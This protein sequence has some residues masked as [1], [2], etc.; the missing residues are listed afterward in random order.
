MYISKPKTLDDEQSTF[1]SGR[2]AWYSTSRADLR[3]GIKQANND[4]RRK[5]EIYLGENNSQSMWQ[6]IQN[7]T[8]YKRCTNSDPNGDVS[9]CEQL[10]CFFARFAANMPVFSS[11]PQPHSGS[12]VL[13]LQEHDVRRVLRVIN[14][15]KASGPDRVPGKVL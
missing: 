5:I 2:E 10:N 14:P 13:T 12:H 15:R 4:Y 6:A 1:S 11:Y 7:I 3:R 8:K 9:L